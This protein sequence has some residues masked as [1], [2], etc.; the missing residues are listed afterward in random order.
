MKPITIILLTVMVTT[1]HLF[2]CDNRRPL[3][4]D[5]IPLTIKSDDP[6]LHLV[7]GILYY[8]G[9][10]LFTG[11]IKQYW[12]NGKE[13]SVTHYMNGKEQGIKETFYP[14]GLCE[15]KRWYT[16][17]E[18]DSLNRG[19]WLNGNIKY[20]YHFNKGEYE[21]YFTEWYENGNIMQRI[22]YVKG[23]E[24]SGMGWRQSG[25][26]YMNYILKNGRRFG[27]VNAN[28]CYSLVNEKNPGK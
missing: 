15:S 2:S 22:L 20:E 11:I 10:L 4:M 14:N 24:L 7:N 5:I 6:R 27:L 8:K 18:K 26:L 3:R 23:E 12:P 17:G 1:L 21:G 25:K 28:L 9:S 13:N 16:K 19:W